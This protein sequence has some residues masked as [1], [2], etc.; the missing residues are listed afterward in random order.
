[1]GPVS[2]FDPTGMTCNSYT[3]QCGTGTVRTSGPHAG[4][5]EYHDPD[6]GDTSFSGS[7]G[8]Q[9]TWDP[10]SVPPVPE[11]VLPKAVFSG[12]V[13]YIPYSP[14]AQSDAACATACPGGFTSLAIHTTDMLGHCT[15]LNFMSSQCATSMQGL[16]TATLEQTFGGGTCRWN[17]GTGHDICTNVNLTPWGAPAFAVGNTVSLREGQDSVDTMAHEDRHV[18]QAGAL[19][20]AYGPA[21]WLS[22]GISWA[23]TGDVGDNNCSLMERDASRFGSAYPPCDPWWSGS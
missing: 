9:E 21:D 22:T 14:T 18:D 6:T 16:A 8:R 23:V 15:P 7:G 17:P 19:G 3:N 10:T 2:G 5:Y 11:P 4:E 1:M 20:W 12:Y 13:T